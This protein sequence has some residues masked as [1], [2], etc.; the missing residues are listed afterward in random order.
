MQLSFWQNVPSGHG[1]AL[2]EQGAFIPLHSFAPHDDI[3]IEG[4]DTWLSKPSEQNP[5]E[6]VKPPGH[7]LL[8]RQGSFA[9]PE[10]TAGN[11]EDDPRKNWSPTN[12]TRTTARNRPNPDPSFRAAMT[13]DHSIEN[14][15]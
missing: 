6:H 7:C 8:A 12:T 2:L 3:S 1:S 10:A 14:Q 4:T 13:S 5:P 11:E 15:G 9:V